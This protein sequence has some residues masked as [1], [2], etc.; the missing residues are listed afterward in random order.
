MPFFAALYTFLGLIA[1]SFLNV[2]IHRIPRGESIV[3]PGSRC[4]Q[5]KK[6]VRPYDNI[7]LVSYLVLRGKCRDCKSPI[8]FRY[9]LVE[10]L[11]ALAF[12]SCHHAWGFSS[13]TFVN[14]LFLSLLIILVFVDYDRQV[15]PDAITRPGILAGILLSPFQAE[16]LFRDAFSY[17]IAL[18]LPSIDPET[19]LPWVGSL[20]GALVGGGILWLTGYAYQLVRKKKGLGLGDVKMMAMVGAFLGWRMALLTIFVG[21]LLGSVIGIFLMRFRGA[22]LQTKLPFGTFLGSG[23][24]FAVF[25]GGRFL[26]WLERLLDDLILRFMRLVGLS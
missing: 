8:S 2:C 15:L 18:G 5:C 21:S 11:T 16:M 4:P 22:T 20:L 14:T 7:P 9:P 1:G 26:L 12:W 10:I 23:A 17:G 3:R 25:F 13:P 19:V 24:A 6:P